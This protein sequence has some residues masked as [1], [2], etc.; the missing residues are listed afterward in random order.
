M[1][2][3]QVEDLVGL[4]RQNI[5]YYEKEGLL[6]PSREKENS[7]RD[8]SKEDV[9]RL[10]MI[11]MLRMLDM[12]L[13]DIE[14]VLKNEVT[15]QEAVTVRQKELLEHQKQ[16]QAAIDICSQLKK[17]KSREISVDKYLEKMEQME[18]SG[19][20]FARILDDY[21]QLIRKEEEKQL[22]FYTDHKI[23]SPAAFE[24]VLK[25]YAKEQGLIFKM[26]EKGKYPRFYFN[27]QLY[28]GV[29]SF[30]NSEYRVVCMKIE[31]P[32]KKGALILKVYSL[33]ANI[34]RHAAKS[35]CSFAF[36]LMMVL[37]LGIY[38]GNLN[39]IR[40]Q[41][42]NLSRSM[43]VYATVYNSTGNANRHLLIKQDF[44]NGVRSSEY[45]S[46]VKETAEL[47]GKNESADHYQILALEDEKLSELQHGQCLVSP[48]FL[49]ENQLQTG[50]KITIAIYFYKLDIMIGRLTE[51]LLTQTTLEIAG[52]RDMEQD[53]HIP[54]THVKEMFQQTGTVYQ[55]SSLSFRV[56]DPR[57][58]N[59]LKNEMK[60]LG[61]QT[62]QF[63]EKETCQGTALGV[64]DAT[65]IEASVK[66]E[67]NKRLLQSFL[68][69]PLELYN[70]NSMI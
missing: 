51:Q 53:I 14:K 65:F 67:N 31:E 15:L 59:D 60:E 19:N 40:T 8:Y 43:P 38:L 23:H 56:K 1:N 39:E 54:L 41:I 5:R 30:E 24:K 20:V 48:M 22:I 46:D 6:S 18:K 47:I 37:M 25:E 63:G 13:K 55:A 21:Q 61:L 9:E 68:L 7:Y 52:S 10:K 3:K 29:Y 42:A 69:P 58:L 64:E 36:S 2:T 57:Q 17:E 66:L 32:Q 28:C 62:I 33:A 34:R 27:E 50:D 12:P 45:V 49:E 26:K 70:K 4:S 11:K 35:I 44:V 16:L